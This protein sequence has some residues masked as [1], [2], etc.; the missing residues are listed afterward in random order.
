MTEHPQYLNHSQVT[1]DTIDTAR[2]RRLAVTLGQHAFNNQHLNPAGTPLPPL[3]HWAFFQPELPATA[4]GTDGHPLAGGFMPPTAGL[5]RMWAGGRFIFGQPLIIGR[6]AECHSHISAVSDKQGLAGRLYFVTLVHQYWQD[7]NLAFTEEQDLVYRTP[8]PAKTHTHMPEQQPQWQHVENP[9]STLLFR[10]SALT[11]NGHRIHYDY[12]YATEIEGYAGLVVHGP[13]M[14]TWALQSFIQT[15]PD[16]IISHYQYRGHRPTTLPQPITVSGCLNPH[17][18]NQAAVWLH[19]DS[20]LI[21]QGSITY[22]EK[23][24]KC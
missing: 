16:K 14:A 19:N 20:G 3:W 11:F 22:T 17:A 23:G 7:G 6:A 8:S 5:Q 24:I 1:K 2:V 15:H 13:M 9:D 10:Y 18:H 4:L 21:Q 12:P